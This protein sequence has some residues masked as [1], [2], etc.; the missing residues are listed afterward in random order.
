MNMKHG[1]MKISSQV[2]DFGLHDE[3]KQIPLYSLSYDKGH[4]EHCVAN[5]LSQPGCA[6]IISIIS[7]GNI[8]SAK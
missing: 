2:L 6:S 3:T 8:Y 5:I 4:L 7:R 1:K